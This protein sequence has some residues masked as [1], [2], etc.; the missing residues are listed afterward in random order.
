MS[1]SSISAACCVHSL[2]NVCYLWS[3][4]HSRLAQYQVWPM[5]MLAAVQPL[6]VSLSL[7]QHEL[8]NLQKDALQRRKPPPLT[9]LADD[10]PSH[11]AAGIPGI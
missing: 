7:S 6:D 10:A 3:V 2:V 5:Q 1:L 9:P 8:E 4:A 11:S